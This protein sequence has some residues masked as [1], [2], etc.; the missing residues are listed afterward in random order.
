MWVLLIAVA[1]VVIGKLTLG[2]SIPL[3]FAAAVFLIS[4]MVV[5]IESWLIINGYRVY[6]ESAVNAFTGF[7]TPITGVPVE[8]AFATPCYMALIVAFIRYWEIVLDNRL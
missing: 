3:R 5:P 4:V 2:L 6:G 8:I 1:A 7:T